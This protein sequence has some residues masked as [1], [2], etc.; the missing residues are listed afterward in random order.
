MAQRTQKKLNAEA[1]W[2]YA[3]RAL[4][5]RAHSVAELSEKLRRRAAH[6]EDVHRV[7]AQLKQ[8]GYLNDRRYAQAFAAS[9]LENEGF[10]KMR[11]LAELRRRRVAPSIAEQAVKKTYQDIDETALIE[12]FLERKFRRPPPAEAL[13]DP[14]RMAAAYR[15]LRL[16]GFGSAAILR[17]LSRYN[18]RAEELESL[19]DEERES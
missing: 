16:A 11:V 4:G 3:L 6:E 1:L 15:K 12:A 7:V 17:V 9:R 19:E 8:Y 10:G 5:G 18:E 2:E 14:R 13:A